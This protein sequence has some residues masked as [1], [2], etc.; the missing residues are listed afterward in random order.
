MHMSIDIFNNKK[1]INY[2]YIVFGI[3]FIIGIILIIIGNKSNKEVSVNNLQ[4]YISLKGDSEITIYQDS[5]YIEP[6][7]VASD[8]LGND[9]TSMVTVDSSL[10]VS[11][12]GKYTIMYILNDT[13]VSRIIN[14]VE[15]EIG[16]SYIYLLGDLTMY[17]EL[18]SQ[19]IEPG[20][21]VVDTVDGGLL[22]DKVNI[23]STVDTSKAGIYRVIYSVVNS[24]GVTTSNQRIVVVMNS[25]VSLYLDNENYTNSD[26]NINIYVKDVYFDYMILPNG[27]KVTEN[28]Y[29]YTISENGDYKFRVYSRKGADKEYTISIA[30]INKTKPTGSCSGSYKNGVS[31]IK[32]V[33]SDDIGILKYVIN[34]STY[35]TDTININGEYNNITVTIYDKANNNINVSCNLSNNNPI[36]PSS[37]PKPQTPTP[38]VEPIPT[39]PVTPPSNNSTTKETIISTNT[40]KVWME[41]HST[42]YVTYVWAANPYRQLK[43]AV[44][45][46]FGNELSRPTAIL[47]GAISKHGFGN[48][49][50]VAVNGSGFVLKGTYDSQ[51][52]YANSS[53]NKT[54]VSPIVIVEGNVL[55]DISNGKIPSSTHITYGLKKNGYL[56]YYT[57]SAGTNVQSN[58]D[59]SKRIINDGVLNTFAFN[60]VLVYNGTVV[61]S[62]TSPNIR[63]GFCQ[64][65]KNNFVFITNNCARNSGFSFKSLGE[66]M[67]SIGCQT[68]FNLDGGGSTTLIYKNG[69]SGLNVVYGNG[70]SIADVL[71][72]HE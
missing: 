34:G 19:Y 65:D 14:V 41:K 21:E 64:I 67:V 4:Y 46:N 18:N 3:I 44:P 68:G 29:A 35:T 27:N 32:M 43:T 28:K 54:S 72:F 7:Y 2:W 48:K 40:L 16:K 36:I 42:F 49:S 50:M 57:Y 58:I 70:R 11:K 39:P 56:G 71:Y 6:G 52:A 1:H 66:Y 55:R 47:E 22:K 15:K 13:K 12:T 9:L 62:G 59:T 5:E 69:N 20:Y 25:D 53:W 60:P 45:N 51:Y 61:S 26:E 17:I 30:N 23:S 31:T 8:S 63:Q 10:D 33:A 37:T 38:T 24:S